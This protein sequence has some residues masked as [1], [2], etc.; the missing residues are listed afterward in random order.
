VSNPTGED[1]STFQQKLAE[2][3]KREAEASTPPP[4][5]SA[6]QL[7]S[8]Y[9]HLA[10]EVDSQ[11]SEE[12]QELDAVLARID[13]ID[14]YI[15]WCGKMTPKPRSGQTEG[16]K[17]SCPIPGHTDNDPSAWINTKD[18]VW[19]CG[20]CQ[21]GGDA[22][23]IAAYHFGFP[24][25]DYKQGATFHDL[26]RK[27]A[28]DFGYTFVTPPGAKQP[29]MV[30][31]EPP[32]EVEHSG[33]PAV[34]SVPAAPELPAEVASVT[35]IYEEDDDDEIIFPT[36]D[37]RQIVEPNT[38]L[39]EF[40][41]ATA[42]DDTPEEFNFWNG[43]IA[44]GLVAGRDVI[45]RDRISVKAN[46]FV[47][48]L[49]HT[50]D[51]KSRS[52]SHLKRL[53]RYALPYDGTDP[54]NK[55]AKI[56][57]TPASAEVL[58]HSFSKPVPD[59]IDPK[60]IA[61]HAPVRG[62]VEWNEL[63]ALTSRTSRTGNALK[64]SLMQF[65]DADDRIATS[66]MGTGTKEAHDSFACVFT[67]T[68]P[69]ALREL[70]RQ[71]DADSGFLNRWVFASGQEKQRIAIGGVEIDLTSSISSLQEV[72]AWTSPGVVGARTIEWSDEAAELFTEFFHRIL[73]PKKKMDQSGL[74]TRIDLLM[75]K[76]ILLLC[77]NQRLDTVPVEV[78]GKTIAMY[79]YLVAAYS[80]PAA[81]LGR[82][83][84]NEVYEDIV[85]H[86]NS[87]T[88]SNGR[89]A[90][91]RDLKVRMKRKDYPVDLIDKALKLAVNHGEIILD[92]SKAGP[93]RPSVRYK[94]VG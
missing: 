37:W 20:G 30:T 22:Y 66:S 68:Q 80:I 76:L 21:V 69:R 31:P 58:I 56:I 83:L 47:C 61:Y 71:S 63:S 14:A 72:A 87:L 64:P 60:K 86:C 36:L 38:F 62:L 55:G 81:Q 3:R 73:Q 85:R 7:P 84:I 77:I 51:G 74:L 1:L 5:P 43:L 10:P 82:S 57:D 8:E 42:I 32:G 48:L 52:Y 70:I 45:L 35:N 33:V 17:I 4:S 28:E 40:C 16:I 34:P 79:D 67:T 91:L 19:F 2:R 25:P 59:P 92:T 78:V 41:R 50:G 93:G 94:Y 49:G 54:N 11:R 90:T 39:D 65:Y 27:M 23:D 15:R 9:E 53:L 29:I 44:L 88:K 24:V 6:P 12:D 13:L 75:K 46:L 18:Q 89:G 26:R